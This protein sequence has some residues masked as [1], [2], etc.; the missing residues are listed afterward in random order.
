MYSAENLKTL[1]RGLG[2]Y[3]LAVPMRKVKQV[4]ANV[5]HRAGRYREV[6]PG[7]EVKE[8]IV[9]AGER[10]RRYLVCRNLDEA[11]WKK[12]HREQIIKTLEQE[13]AALASGTKITPSGPASYS[14]PGALDG[15]SEESLEGG[16]ASILRR[17]GRRK[18]LTAST[19]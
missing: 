8:V 14:P 11:K 13:L 2:R 7:L 15:I 4:K 18:N 9:G 10:R 12:L 16:F 3:I 5:L 17:S 6:K 19:C 1:S